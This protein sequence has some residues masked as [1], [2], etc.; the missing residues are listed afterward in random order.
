MNTLDEIEAR[1]EAATAGEWYIEEEYVVSQVLPLPE[2]AEAIAEFNF[3]SD[4]VFCCDARTYVPLLCRALRI[5]AYRFQG[6]IGYPAVSQDYAK[7]WMNELLQEAQD[8]KSD[9]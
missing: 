9:G 1:C 7:L 5:A 8:D 3:T 2:P 6:A 4:A